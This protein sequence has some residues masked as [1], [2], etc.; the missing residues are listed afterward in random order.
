[1]K[2]QWILM[3][4]SALM[5]CCLF[6]FMPGT[7]FANAADSSAYYENNMFYL[8]PSGASSTDNSDLYASILC[9]GFYGYDEH[10]NPATYVS[11]NNRY[12][13]YGF[14]TGYIKCMYKLI[15][16][17][18]T[19]NDLIIPATNIRLSVTPV[20]NVNNM[21][22]VDIDWNAGQLMVDRVN[23][24]GYLYFSNAPD[25]ALFSYIVVPHGGDISCVFECTYHYEASSSQA[26]TSGILIEVTDF[27][28]SWIYPSIPITPVVVAAGDAVFTSYESY[29]PYIY[30][31]TT[32]IW[33]S[34]KDQQTQGEGTSGDAEDTQEQI[35]T[36][37]G[38]EQTWYQG[39]ETA[40]EGTGLS[41]F[42]FG[43]FEPRLGTVMSDFTAVWNAM[44]YFTIAPIFA[45]SLKVATTVIRHMPRRKRMSEKDD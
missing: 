12:T 7:V 28:A 27:N 41:T 9:T 38:T 8:S 35:E 37:H 2:R 13:V 4:V 16:R 39:T 21:E 29:L 42:T 1:M 11:G 36:I 34:L 10:L 20:T 22:L 33:E 25:N 5:V 24:S 23:G 18:T 32:G 30:Y 19:S 3:S 6:V 17:N 43:T 14:A 26:G 31:A 44:D 45:L 40:L 15:I